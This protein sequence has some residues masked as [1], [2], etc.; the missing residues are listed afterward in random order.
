[1]GPPWELKFQNATSPYTVSVCFQPKCIIIG[2][3]MGEY[4][5]LPFWRPATFLDFYGTLKFLLTQDHMG[6][7]FQN[8]IPLTVFV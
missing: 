3:D 2:L 4:M 8:G 5:T 1:M 7:T 6:W